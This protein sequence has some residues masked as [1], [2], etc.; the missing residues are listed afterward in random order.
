MNRLSL[1]EATERLRGKRVVG[2]ESAEDESGDSMELTV[3][4]DE[5]PPL[6]INYCVGMNPPTA[7]LGEDVIRTTWEHDASTRVRWEED[8]ERHWRWVK[9]GRIVATCW[10]GNA[11]WTWEIWGDDPDKPILTGLVQHMQAASEAVLSEVQ[12]LDAADPGRKGG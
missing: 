11:G 6:V 1:A 12:R 10:L 7:R 9:E 5:G 4:F 8:G 3:R 2:L